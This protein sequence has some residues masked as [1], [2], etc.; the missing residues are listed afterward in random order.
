MNIMSFDYIANWSGWIYLFGAFLALAMCIRIIV[1]SKRLKK[2]SM[3]GISRP[4][5]KLSLSIGITLALIAIGFSISAYHFFKCSMCGSL[6]GTCGKE[7]IPS[8]IIV[9]IG[10]VGL[11][12]NW[13]FVEQML[14]VYK[15]I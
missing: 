14:K 12:V 5:M 1:V 3:I 15:M 9:D 6:A 11:I 7:L 2:G 10:L 4:F 13:I 8:A